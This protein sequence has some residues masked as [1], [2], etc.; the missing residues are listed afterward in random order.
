MDRWEQTDGRVIPHSALVAGWDEEKK[1]FTPPRISGAVICPKIYLRILCKGGLNK[2]TFTL[3][4]SFARNENF[5]I[6]GWQALG[7]QQQVFE[8][9]QPMDISTGEV[10]KFKFSKTLPGTTPFDMNLF[11]KKD[12]SS[13]NNN[14]NSADL[15]RPYDNNKP[16]TPSN[17][18][19]M[20]EWTIQHQEDL[21]AQREMEKQD[22]DQAMAAIMA[23]S[24]PLEHDETAMMEPPVVLTKTGG[25]AGKGEKRKAEGEPEG[26]APPTSGVSKRGGGGGKKQKLNP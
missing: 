23:Q 6:R 3:K 24:G 4:A 2:K 16:V 20:G 14:S 7:Q 25:G 5:F 1:K 10:K 12:S 15:Y 19:S 8:E 22:A 21:K 13:N 17:E 11:N 18:A 26:G 9:S